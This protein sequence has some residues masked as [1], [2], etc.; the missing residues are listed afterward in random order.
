[1]KVGGTRA[2]YKRRLSFGA[3]G[4]VYIELA[5]GA[6]WLAKDGV[7]YAIYNGYINRIYTNMAGYT[8]H[9]N[10]SSTNEGPQMRPLIPAYDYYWN[11]TYTVT[12]DAS[13]STVASGQFSISANAHAY[14]PVVGVLFSDQQTFTIK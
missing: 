8:A 12:H 11:G 1:M 9:V 5:I 2:A 10:I 7:V 6:V 4:H 3:T 14:L 13:G